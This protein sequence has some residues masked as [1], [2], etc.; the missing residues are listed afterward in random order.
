MLFRDIEP[1]CGVGGFARTGPC[2]AGLGLLLRHRGV[3]PDGVDRPALFAQRVLRQVQ[4]ETVGVIK[5]ERRLARQVCVLRQP[6][7]RFIQKVKAAIQSLAEPVFLQLERFLD[8]RLRPAKLRESLA[9]LSHQRRHQTVHQRRV[10]TQ[11]VRMT[12]RPAHDPAQDIAPP[13]VRRQHAVGDQKGRRAQVIRDHP[14]MHV[15]RPVR[16]HAGSV[17]G[18]LDQR[19]HQVGVVIVVL[20]LQD[21]AD[22]LQ[23]HAG[24]D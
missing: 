20:A 6:F 3:E 19:P 11:Q 9:H 10:D 7:Q 17:G 15:L 1:D 23:P 14:V 8:Q 2:R 22:P 13:L 16:L 5:L 21:R 18:G 12:H 4:R 24:V